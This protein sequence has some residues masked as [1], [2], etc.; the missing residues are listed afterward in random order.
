LAFSS[1]SRASQE[2]KTTLWQ[3]YIPLENAFY[4][5]SGLDNY[6]TNL[7]LV[8]MDRFVRLQIYATRS[9]A[10]ATANGQYPFRKI[11]FAWDN[12]AGGNSSLLPRVPLLAKEFAHSLQGAYGYGGTARLAC[13]SAAHP[14]VSG[15]PNIGLCKPHDDL[16]SLK[17]SWN[18]FGSGW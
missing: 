14:S 15:V 18:G 17:S 3:K 10:T 11:G 2:A 5:N 1:T 6:N 16:A 7:P 13:T 12:N 8:T 9:W 4:G